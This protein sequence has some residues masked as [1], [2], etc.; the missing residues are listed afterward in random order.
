MAQTQQDQI[1]FQH[2]DFYECQTGSMLGLEDEELASSLAIHCVPSLDGRI[3]EAFATE[4]S[5]PDSRVQ[6]KQQP[7]IKCLH[8]RTAG[9][10]KGHPCGKTIARKCSDGTFLCGTHLRMLRAREERELELNLLSTS[11]GTKNS[12]DSLRSAFNQSG[13]PGSPAGQAIPNDKFAQASPECEPIVR[14]GVDHSDAD[15]HRDC[16]STAAKPESLPYHSMTDSQAFGIDG[17]AIDDIQSAFCP[18]KGSDEL[19]SA[20]AS[21]A[22]PV[23]EDGLAD[24]SL[25]W[26]AN[27]DGI[28]TE[29]FSDDSLQLFRVYSSLAHYSPND[30]QAARRHSF[31]DVE[32][33]DIILHSELSGA[34]SGITPLDVIEDGFDY[35]MRFQASNILDIWEEV[36][37]NWPLTEDDN[38]EYDDHTGVR[39]PAIPMD[40]DGLSA[41]EEGGLAGNSDREVCVIWVGVEDMLPLQEGAE[42]KTVTRSP[43]WVLARIN[44]TLEKVD[45]AR[46][47]GTV[48]ILKMLSR[49]KK[50]WIYDNARRTMRLRLA[51]MG[52]NTISESHPR[53]AVNMKILE[54]CKTLL[55]FDMRATKRDLYYRDVDLFRTQSVVDHAIEDLACT[56]GV[57]RHC[58]NIVASSKGLVSGSLKLHMN[59]G[60][61]IDCS[62]GGEQGQLIPTSEQIL[63]LET[64]AKFVLV[65][66]K[67]ATFRTLVCRGYPTHEPCILITGKGYPDVSTR[68]LV[69]RLAELRLRLPTDDLDSLVPIQQQ[70]HASTRT[71]REGSTAPGV[72]TTENAEGRSQSQLA[73]LA[74]MDCDPH[75]IAIYMCYKN[76]SSAMAFDA[77]NL[78][79]PRLQWLGLT[80]RDWAEFN[81]SQDRLLPLTKRDRTKA[82]SILKRDELCEQIGLRRE[83]ARL[84]L[85]NHKA[86]I[87][88]LDDDILVDT[89]LPTK[90][91]FVQ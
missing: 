71:H 42:W 24:G 50:A 11:A 80:P 29:G 58:L 59:N 87:Q 21:D 69:K 79:C 20:L 43:A 63:E 1:V 56:L 4:E 55:E 33:S 53:F 62:S 91:A 89:Y 39:E 83:L 6:S 73:M 64:D 88:A 54:F 28:M 66:E 8:V 60:D 90:V 77:E 37:D 9:P 27:E 85:C 86:E 16:N 35:S 38:D 40:L 51:N 7:A 81:I 49:N 25:H 14:D 44:N 84:L 12:A 47:T 2:G 3:T 82:M 26:D 15:I 5:V 67:E 74:L 22:A 52:F 75:G 17:Y 18:G 19:N 45:D 57:S 68:R 70:G 13:S 61:V 34:S 41:R 72:A 10:R 76:G 32:H 36:D 78:A 30:W 46:S 65:V 23:T 48:P 31:R